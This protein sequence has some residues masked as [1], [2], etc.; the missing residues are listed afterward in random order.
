M[1]LYNIKK[2]SPEEFYKQ[3]MVAR[4]AGGWRVV[5][6]TKWYTDIRRNNTSAGSHFII[7]LI[8]IIMGAIIYWA[9]R[10][11]FSMVAILPVIANWAYYRLAR[12]EQRVLKSIRQ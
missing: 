5:E 9:T 4:M 7:T 3:R 10:D 8:F 2:K 12:E 6:D 11:Y 1:K